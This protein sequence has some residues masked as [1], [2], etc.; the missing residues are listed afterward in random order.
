MGR[1]RGR[2]LC[3]FSRGQRA[4]SVKA[5]G[6]APSAAAPNHHHGGKHHHSRGVDAQQQQQQQQQQQKIE[7][8]VQEMEVRIESL[9]GDLAREMGYPLAVRLIHEVS[10]VFDPNVENMSLRKH[11][12]PWGW[13]HRN[14]DFKR[15][16]SE[17]GNSIPSDDMRSIDA[18]SYKAAHIM[19]HSNSS[20]LTLLCCHAYACPLLK[21]P[22]RLCL[23]TL[24]ML[25]CK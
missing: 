7:L 2:F 9:K 18:I 14:H 3:C 5:P 1:S 8:Q 12:N 25:V 10:A 23:S 4:A 13:L 11:P 24:V 20:L 15:A 17:Q 21:R 6:D 22:I 19:A 16:L